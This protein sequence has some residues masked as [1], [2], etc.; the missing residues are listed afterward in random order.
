MDDQNILD[1][2]EKF[3]NQDNLKCIRIWKP[4]IFKCEK[5]PTIGPQSPSTSGH[6]LTW[7]ESVVHNEEESFESEKVTEEKLE[8]SAWEQELEDVTCNDGLDPLLKDLK[9]PSDIL[10]QEKWEQTGTDDL[11]DGY[12][13][14]H[15]Q[16]K[17]KR[18]A[19]LRTHISTHLEVRDCKECD[20]RSVDKADLESHYLDEHP[21]SEPRR[22]KTYRKIYHA[23]FAKDKIFKCPICPY[24]SNRKWN[25]NSHL[26]IHSK[27]KPLQKRKY[28]NFNKNVI[29]D[30]VP[31]N[32]SPHCL[33]YD[34]LPE[35][36]QRFIAKDCEVTTSENQCSSIASPI[37]GYNVNMNANGDEISSSTR[38]PFPDKIVN[39]EVRLS[40][41]TYALVSSSF[42]KV[43]PSTNLLLAKQYAEME[44]CSS[45]ASAQVSSSC[46]LEDSNI[47]TS[48]YSLD[49]D[50][51]TS[52]SGSDLEK[53][54]LLK[55]IQCSF[56]TN[57]Q[58]ILKD[59]ISSH[60]GMKLFN[61][62]KCD[63]STDQRRYFNAHILSHSSVEIFKC[64]QCDYMT[65]R[66]SSLKAHG[67]THVSYKEYKCNHCS[68]ET[69]NNRNLKT[70]LVIHSEERIYRCSECDYET[71]VEKYLKTHSLVHCP[72]EEQYKCSECE[73]RTPRKGQL[74]IHS[75]KHTDIKLYKCLVCDFKTNRKCSLK[76]HSLSHST[77]KLYKCTIC[78]YD[79]NQKLL[80]RLH[81]LNH[82]NIKLYK[83]PSCD[84]GTNHSSH[85]KRHFQTHI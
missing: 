22:P 16:V 45:V 84:Y 11:D 14:P 33:G 55:C 1:E 42:N 3:E 85:F 26:K 37:F 72:E 77:Q 39:E 35:T 4:H 50:V 20:Y 46:P 65:N 10:S 73:Y 18:K 54:V 60:P 5:S 28:E 51:K 57:K 6:S 59:H 66:K 27:M 58:S 70:H 68:F 53:P 2:E 79:T 30:F 32:A 31:V 13:C 36:S 69:H 38:L 15:C 49:L 56:T 81:V 23:G 63:F 25:V 41:N 47:V 17:V 40:A 62:A 43:S 74:R 61:C 80:L 24:R 78:K 21:D 9:C 71:N 19:A 29:N 7:F 75:L 52:E 48:S 34:D 64:D 8:T 82:L 83:C 67:L 44:S 76:V 12:K